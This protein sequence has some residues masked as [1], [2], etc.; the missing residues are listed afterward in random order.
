MWDLT[1]ATDHDFYVRV[2]AS[3]VLVHNCPR[4]GGGANDAPS[5]VAR[6]AGLPLAGESAQ[7]YAARILDRTYG[8]GNWA[9]GAVGV[10]QDCEVGDARREVELRWGRRSN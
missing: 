1:V 3:N 5:W 6:E 2:G 4:A 7:Q 10:Q 8:I 9:K